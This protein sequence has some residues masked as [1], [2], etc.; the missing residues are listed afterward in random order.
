M[1]GTIAR[2]AV[3]LAGHPPGINAVDLHR[4]RIPAA[5][6]GSQDFGLH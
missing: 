3:S 6:A 5:P 2:S 4:Y 1:D